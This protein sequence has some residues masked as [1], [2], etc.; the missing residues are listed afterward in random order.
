MIAG[1]DAMIVDVNETTLASI[2]NP[3]LRSYAEQYVRNQQDFIQQI[4]QVGIDVEGRTTASRSSERIVALAKKGAVVRND[5]KSVYVNRISPACEACQ[6]GVGSQ[7]F[8]M[9]LKCHRNCFF[10]FNPN[11]MGY[12]FQREHMRDTVGELDALRASGQRFQHL[13]L[14]GGEPLLHKEETVR[15]FQHARQTYPNVYTRLYTCG[16]HLERETL[17][18]LKDA[19][20]NEI[21]ISIRIEDN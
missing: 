12:E 20:L 17:Q 9:S 6:I 21:R 3:A 15:F 4:R 5:G 7:T 16:D 8:S 13:A 18:A 11:Q 10:C 2:Q 14:T 1:V 19:G